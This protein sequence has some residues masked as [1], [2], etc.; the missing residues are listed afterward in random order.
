V[1]AA[2]DAA[3]EED[4]GMQEGTASVDETTD[5]GPAAGDQATAEETV[6]VDA[7]LGAV[8]TP[9][10]DRAAEDGQAE[11]EDTG[12]DAKSRRED[13]GEDED[14]AEG[15]AGAAPDETAAEVT[16]AGM[17]VDDAASDG[18]V[19]EDLPED[20][21]SE[22]SALIEDTGLADEN[23]EEE[24]EEELDLLVSEERRRE[25]SD[26]EAGLDVDVEPGAAP[27]ADAVRALEQAALVEA[28]LA[29][30]VPEPPSGVDLVKL[31]ETLNALQTEMVALRSL[32]DSLGT[33]LR[34]RLDAIHE[35]LLS[36]AGV[37]NPVGPGP[38]AMRAADVVTQEV[39][40]VPVP[41]S[42]DGP[43]EE[44]VAP[45][46]KRSGRRVLLVV[47]LVVLGL[48]LAG[49]IVL[50]GVYG[51]DKVRSQ[52]NGLMV[53]PLADGGMSAPLVG[54]AML[55]RPVRRE[56]PPLEPD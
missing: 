39:P 10:A 27:L 28:E 23:G 12:D 25:E 41:I 46:A 37:L 50:T 30:V 49:L 45:P 17:A 8:P 29:Q 22:T 40:P 5:E 15:A 4:E 2:D 16:V 24:L 11:P 6:A 32:V 19:E 34:E 53:H 7:A 54:M 1:Q 33:E 20:D 42:A 47:V 51:W 52:V 44:E 56:E 3:G 14:E 35:D 13:E 43:V 21:L 18:L 38:G 31:T 26:E 36:N 9:E 55:H 48:L